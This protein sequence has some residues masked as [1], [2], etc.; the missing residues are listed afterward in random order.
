MVEAAVEGNFLSSFSVSN[1][2][3]GSISILHLHF[4]ANTLIFS[5]ADHGYIQ[6]LRNVL[7]CFE[8][9]SSLKVSLGKSELVPMGKVNDINYLASLLACK[10]A[11]LP[12]KYLGLPLGGNFQSPCHLV[13]VSSTCRGKNSFRVFLWGG[14][15]EEHLVSRNKA[16]SP[17]SVAMVGCS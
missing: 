10:I 7:L 3:N 11:S 8:I 9:V 14:M 12:V 1:A 2:I 5:Y 15:G 17:L 6:T 16:C 4:T 13:V